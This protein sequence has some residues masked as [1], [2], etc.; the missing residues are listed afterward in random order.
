MKYD[1]DTTIQRFGTDSIKWDVKEG[2]L[3]MW[4]ADMD[5]KTAPQIIE[6]IRKR[7]EHGVFGYMSDRPEWYEAYMNW[8]SSRHSFEMSKE[9]L[10]FST[11]VIPI[12]SSTVRKL[13]TPGEKIVIQTPVYNVFTNCIVNNGCTVAENRLLYENGAYSIDWDDLEAKLADP[14]V[15]LMIL[16]NP[17]NPIGKIWDRETLAR[18]GE[19]CAAYNV[20]V[21]SDE[22]HCDV[23][24][25]GC[26]YVPF[27]SVSPVCRDNCIMCIAPTKAFNI[28][29]LK[30]AAACIPNKDLRHKVWRAINTDEVAEPNSFAI[31]A[32]VAAFNESGDWLDEMCKYV[33]G[34]RRRVAEFISSELPSLSLVPG[35]ATYL[36]WIDISSLGMPSKKVAEH[37]RSTTGLFVTAGRYYGENGDGFLRMNVACPRTTLEDGLERLKRGVES[38][39]DKVN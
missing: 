33:E 4:V 3:P 24:A 38:L 7:A 26:E 29:G 21:I 2:E 19:M 37:I 14:Q 17:H 6:A 1:F 27:A 34:N 22:I 11:G 35:N 12:I 20:V 25:P 15:S 8:W 30:S 16:C 10:L 32:A 28:A 36:L 31:V 18:I 23:T 5:F 39:Q 9:W 13:A